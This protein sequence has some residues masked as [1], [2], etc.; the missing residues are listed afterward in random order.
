MTLL[1]LVFLINSTI[2]LL[3]INSEIKKWKKIIVCYL[4]TLVLFLLFLIKKLFNVSFYPFILILLIIVLKVILL[5]IICKLITLTKTRIVLL[6][7]QT[8]VFLFLVIPYGK[9]EMN[10]MLHKN[11]FS[12]CYRQTNMISDVEYLKVFSY[13]KNKAKV[14]YKSKDGDGF[15]EDF[16]YLK[17]KNGKWKMYNWETIWASS[18]S[19]SE[20]TYPL[21]R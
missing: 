5:I 17:K 1:L 3:I 6:I 10:T 13:S 9:V 20:F 15:G 12:D 18:G 14:F 16:V 4:D 11:E 19:A 8:I 21:Y 2:Q 7:I